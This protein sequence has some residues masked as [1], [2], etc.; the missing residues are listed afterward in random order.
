M[1]ES[2]TTGSFANSVLHL[3]EC[4][5][6]HPHWLES[7]SHSLQFFFPPKVPVFGLTVI[8]ILTCLLACV[9][10]CG[11]VHLCLLYGLQASNGA[12]ACLMLQYGPHE[13]ISGVGSLCCQFINT[14]QR[15]GIN[16]NNYY[17]SEGF[18]GLDYQHFIPL[19]SHCAAMAAGTQQ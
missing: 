1:E 15:T 9:Q 4:L 2:E 14:M 10:S 8:N 12:Q 13:A 6:T 19:V 16:G 3:L 5:W 17:G 18:W 11:F 7:V